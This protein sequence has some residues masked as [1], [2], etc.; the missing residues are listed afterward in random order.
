MKRISL[1]FL[2][3]VLFPLLLNGQIKIDT[4]GRILTGE[5]PTYTQD[6]TKIANVMIHGKNGSYKAGGK[7]TFGDFGSRAKKSCN[8]F[9]GEYSDTDDT[10]Q[11]WL[12]GKSGLYITQSGTAE[13]VVAYYNPQVNARFV[14]NMNLRANGIDISSDAR[15]KENIEPLTNSLSSLN[16]LNAVSYNLKSTNTK[17]SFPA[18]TQNATATLAE[19][20]DELNEKEAREIIRERETEEKLSQEASR[21]RI[22]LL[23]QDLQKVFP[24]LVTTD[25]NGMLSID[26]I[27]LIPVIIEGMKEQNAIIAAQSEK[28]KELEHS[29]NN[30][31][32]NELVP[33]SRKATTEIE[34]IS[35]NQNANA[36]LYQNTPNPFQDQTEIRYFVPEGMQEAYI[37]IFNMQGT[38]L[39]KSP[40]DSSGSLIIRS[41]ELSSGMYI[42][43]LIADGKEI[44]TKR[45]I[46]T[47]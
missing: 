41:A 28:I 27:G 29:N 37:C 10:D 23:A 33:A 32:T 8:V 47:D 42:Y 30:N 36:F 9:I 13:E 39:K 3:P 17:S 22:G 35:A 12:H 43:T 44:D 19:T 7:L 11:L 20:T 34:N 26:Y 38:L 4:Y 5:L 46:L 24:E 45:M 31:L 2:L 16:K 40:T 15:L 21:K 1:Y 14:F 6:T 25:E 18:T